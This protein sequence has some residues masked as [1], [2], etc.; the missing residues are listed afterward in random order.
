MVV[1]PDALEQLPFSTPVRTWY[2]DPHSPPTSR[3]TTHS[4]DAS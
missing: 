3:A 4:I 1:I 2:F